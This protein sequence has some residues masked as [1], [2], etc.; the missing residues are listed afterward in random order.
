MSSLYKSNV[1][2]GK[3]EADPIINAGFHFLKGFARLAY[4]CHQKKM[5]RFP[6]APKCHMLF[7]VVHKMKVQ[8]Q[9]V[10][11]LEN[12]IMFSTA[13]D[14]D[15]IGR[16]CYLTRCVSPRQRILRSIQRYLTQV[17]LFWVRK[18]WWCCQGGRWK[19]CA[20]HWLG[21]VWQE[22]LYSNGLIWLIWVVCGFNLVEIS[23]FCSGLS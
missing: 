20:T 5:A 18:R 22:G 23:C 6:L 4:L 13:S 12:P 1:Y 15:F 9:L 21:R 11:F 10:G 14:E 3:E 17:Y 16:Y 7:H 2:I 8:I 19:W